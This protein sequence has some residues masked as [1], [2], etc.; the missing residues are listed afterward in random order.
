MNKIKSLLALL[1]ALVCGGAWAAVGDTITISNIN[2]GTSR[3]AH[4]YT[5]DTYTICVPASETLPNGSVVRVNK[6]TLGM[7]ST[8]DSAKMPKYLKI[9]ET[10]SAIANGTGNQN[11][12]NKFATQ[13][14]KQEY[15]FADKNLDLTVGSEY[16]LSMCSDEN[17][18]ILSPTKWHD[19]QTTDPTFS[20]IKQ[21][22]S[23]TNF[24]I[25]Q[26]FVGVV[27]SI[28]QDAAVPAFIFDGASN[29]LKGW[30]TTWPESSTNMKGVAPDGSLTAVIY[31]NSRDDKW[32]PYNNSVDALAGNEFTWA[33]YINIEAANKIPDQGDEGT[34]A[35]GSVIYRLGNT[36][37]G[38]FLICK[39]GA[40]GLCTNN[41]TTPTLS[42]PAQ[43]VTPGFHLV[44]ITFSTT[45]GIGLYLDDGTVKDTNAD[46]KTNINNGFQIG[47][48]GSFRRAYGVMIAKILGYEKALTAAE[49]QTLSS[50]FPAA[51]TKLTFDF[52]SNVADRTVVV[53][54]TTSTSGYFGLT[55]GKMLV[56]A[57]AT[58]N[59]TFLKMANS[60]SQDVNLTLD[61]AG[62]LN[63]TSSHMA[64]VGSTTGK[65]A[66]FGHYQGHAT[67]NIT[68]TFSSPNAY[69]RL[70]GDIQEMT[71]NINGGTFETLAILNNAAG[72]VWNGS[73]RGV[74][75]INLTNNGTLK[76]GN[77]DLSTAGWNATINRNF[78]YGTYKNS[79]STAMTDSRP[80]NFTDA[81]NGTT[82]D[83]TTG[84]MTI[85]G[86]ISG[87]GKVVTKGN[88]AF[89]GA[90]S[91]SPSFNVVSGTLSLSA[92]TEGTTTV[93]DGATLKLRVTDAQIQAGYTATNVILPQGQNIDF[94]NAQGESLSDVS[95]NVLS[96]AAKKWIGGASGNWSDDANWSGNVKPTSSDK[97]ALDVEGVV[98]TIDE[99]TTCQASKV[100]VTE[101][102]TLVASGKTVSL[103]I[104][105]DRGKTLTIGS[106][107]DT[108][109]TTFTG[110]ISGAGSVKTATATNKAINLNASNTFTGGLTVV[111][112][113]MVSNGTGYGQP[114]N[115]NTSRVTVESGAVLDVKGMANK[116][117]WVT[118]NG[119]EI[120][121]S[122]SDI[123]TGNLQVSGLTINADT[124]VSGNT[125]GVV[126][127][128]W[129]AATIALDNNT[130][131]VK[132]NTSGEKYFIISHATITGTGKILVEQSR[133][134]V[135]P[136]SSNSNNANYGCTFANG[137]I[138][139]KS[140]AKLSVDHFLTVKNVINNG[141]INGSKTLTV[142]SALTG[143]VP[144]GSGNTLGGIT[145][146]D[147]AAITLEGE[148]SVTANTVTLGNNIAF[149]L[150][151]KGVTADG[152]VNKAVLLTA[153][154][155]DA[156]A[157]VNVKFNDWWWATAT[158]DGGKITVV[159]PNS[160]PFTDNLGT[161]Q[162]VLTGVTTL[163]DLAENY[164]LIAKMTGAWMGT[165]S[166]DMRAYAVEMNDA[167]TELTVEFQG[168]D[169][170]TNDY[171]ARKAL[172]VATVVFTE[173]EGVI[174]AQQRYQGNRGENENLDKL[175]QKSGITST[176][177]P[178]VGDYKISAIAAVPN[179]MADKFTFD[180]TIEN[181]TV[182]QPTGWATSFDNSYN[183]NFTGESKDFGPALGE[184][185]C[186]TTSS[187]HP[188]A[189][190]GFGSKPEYTLA[191]YANPIM[192]VSSS[193]QAVMLCVGNNSKAIYIKKATDGKIAADLYN[194][195]SDVTSLTSND[196]EATNG[197][198]LYIVT[199]DA[200]GV[201]AFYV[202]G[203]FVATASKDYAPNDGFQIASVFQ[204]LSTYADAVD[205]GVAGV[206]GFD[207]ALTAEQVK[208]LTKSHP[209]VPMAKVEGVT[210][211]LRDVN[212]T[213]VLQYAAAAGIDT[214]N[215]LA[216]QGSNGIPL[217]QSAVLGLDP[218]D[219]NST[220]VVISGAQT[221]DA[222]SMKLLTGIKPNPEIMTVTLKSGATAACDD[223]D[224]TPMADDGSFTVTLPTGDGKVKYYKLTYEFQ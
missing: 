75:T 195:S 201:Y 173:T 161:K 223:T 104:E 179:A 171:G 9:G 196:A 120:T 89:T 64:D 156:I 63:I 142:N 198:H 204:G 157:D 18:T 127:S 73:Q 202:D 13:S 113:T 130:L 136:C 219:E 45:N 114:N 172:K 31:Q 20:V 138:E 102:M 175:G 67:Y 25:D 58:V 97:V 210:A 68:G 84:D 103:P 184:M 139:V 79:S 5:G 143:A 59:A 2:K 149:N 145:F 146:A 166:L 107:V 158:K 39:D 125:W 214:T 108:D 27:Q 47:L 178:G 155:A 74:P 220:T 55:Q 11:A 61:L 148:Q 133:L 36:S 162:Q 128:S 129:G 51:T 222:G 134:Y 115:S 105:I 160:K 50:F 116:G 15:S 193:K 93:A 170:Y 207:R 197:Y 152:D 112:G 217:W 190:I 24:R 6:I 38:L 183:T 150:S 37:N 159:Y 147:N 199:K 213:K 189:G 211:P 88:V 72:R 81:E 1:A 119:G 40:L 90:F 177:S 123:G 118:S 182:K 62:T 19:E 14:L 206:Y 124:T 209:A 42:I 169:S 137:T 65:G 22:T 95:G 10:Y 29:T 181:N 98:I 35:N 191:L 216:A 176:T 174:Y 34:S 87:N 23:S 56:P 41:N 28:P 126:A 132:M 43:N 200:N 205:M 85:T 154:D 33:S 218:T 110:V 215:G 86:S 78:G 17:G 192:T 83:A 46:Y 109:N 26:E 92:G 60:S 187:Q 99:A 44:T 82:I 49:I 53:G 77:G 94:V 140:G 100:F 221:T 194:G 54:A 4:D 131:K 165:R 101:N 96:P 8:S 117:Y 48:G 91:G 180:G 164:T 3:N 144:G 151:V 12:S 167:G 141:T 168:I 21:S 185:V 188:Y 163:K 80:I 69:T 212:A 57:G 186:K 70:M 16:A 71:I 106:S 32:H 135:N 76:L 153:Q 122:G 224:V 52:D 7:N 208:N 203:D 121:N 111:S 30:F 66:F